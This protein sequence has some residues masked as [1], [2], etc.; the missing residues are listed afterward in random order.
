MATLYSLHGNHGVIAG[1]EIDTRN[2]DAFVGGL[3]RN[4]APQDVRMFNDRNG[5]PV[6]VVWTREADGSIRDV[7]EFVI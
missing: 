3:F 5:E 7:L 4:G 6:T 2:A 1:Q